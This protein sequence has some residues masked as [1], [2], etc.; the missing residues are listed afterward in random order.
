MS[1]FK[2]IFHNIL[3]E[4]QSQ[5][6]MI[7]P[8]Q[9]SDYVGKLWK[10]YNLHSR[11]IKKTNKETEARMLYATKNDLAVMSADAIKNKV[12][13]SDKVYN[14][15]KGVYVFNTEDSSSLDVKIDTNLTEIDIYEYW[16]TL[17]E[18]DV[19]SYYDFKLQSI[20]LDRSENEHVSINANDIKDLNL[21][22]LV[23]YA[24]TLKDFKTEFTDQSKFFTINSADKNNGIENIETIIGIWT[25]SKKNKI[26]RAFYISE[27]EL[28]QDIIFFM[29]A[30]DA[31]GDKKVLSDLDN[32]KMINFKLGNIIMMSASDASKINNNM[33]N[34]FDSFLFVQK[35]SDKP[36]WVGEKIYTDQ[37][38]VNGNEVDQPIQQEHR[39]HREHR[40]LESLKKVDLY[41]FLKENIKIVVGEDDN[42]V[43]VV[44]EEDIISN[45]NKDPS[46][47][48]EPVENIPEQDQTDLDQKTSSNNN[49]ALNKLKTLLNGN[50]WVIGPVFIPNKESQTL[51]QNCT[52]GTLVDTKKAIVNATKS[53]AV[54]VAR[55]FSG[56]DAPDISDADN[57]LQNIIKKGFNKAGR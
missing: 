37:I 34:S 29:T 57:P 10:I 31:I 36:N 41:N 51:L 49:A 3:K 42:D 9:V 48:Q 54:D 56:V 7:F 32:N 27:T 35:S 12:E 16:K 5:S 15:P 40:D 22:R 21:I 55:K 20:S 52:R 2:S 33:K 26:Q 25:T 53:T 45:D 43:T 18:N 50:W 13:D 47:Q 30:K 11:P 6:T 23:H 38:I 17:R 39:E 8:K 28:D 19:T 1:K 44:N 14:I 24:G 46:I 4:E